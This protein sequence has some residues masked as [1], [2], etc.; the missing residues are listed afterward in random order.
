MSREATLD[1]FFSYSHRDADLREQ[2]EKHLALLKRRQTI[3]TWYDGEITAGEERSPELLHQLETAGVVLLLISPDFIASDFC[4]RDEMTRALERHE[5]GE[6]RVIPILLR[7]VDDW[8]N[9]PF[10]KLQALPERGGAATEWDDLDRAFKNVAAGVRKAVEAELGKRHARHEPAA[11][12]AT[13]PLRVVMLIG[14]SVAEPLPQ[15]AEMARATALDFQGSGLAVELRIDE[16][17]TAH[18]EREAEQGCDLFIYYGHGTEDGRLSFADSS[19]PAF[20]KPVL[21][22]GAALLDRHRRWAWGDDGGHV[23]R[24]S[25]PPASG[26]PARSAAWDSLG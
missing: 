16:A 3:R 1:V 4:W 12:D 13:R 26:I 8:Q 20:P 11:P 15:A 25:R 7:P 22:V 5:A 9:A 23:H 17:T 19:S 24:I 18:F 10:G 6:A 21:E 2:L 14:H